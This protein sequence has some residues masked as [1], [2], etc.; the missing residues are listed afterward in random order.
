[1]SCD[2]EARSYYLT[3]IEQARQKR[4]RL[5]AN[6]RVGQSLTDAILLDVATHVETAPAHDLPF[7][8]VKETS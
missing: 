8:R 7:D 1:M 2:S 6:S 4:S 3:S 5:G